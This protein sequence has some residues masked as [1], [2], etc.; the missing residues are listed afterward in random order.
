M[1]QVLHALL[2]AGT[3]FALAAC[4]QGGG[5]S[6]SAGTPTTYASTPQPCNY[7]A[8][9]YGA[10]PSNCSQYSNYYS[11]NP[12]QYGWYSGAWQWP[13][14]YQTSVGSCGCQ[15]GYF[16]VQSHYYG[17]AC[18]PNAYRSGSF[19]GLV[20]F[21]VGSWGPY[22]NYGQN[23][24]GWLNQQQ[25]TYQPPQN[26]NNCGQSTAQGCDVRVA[27]SCPS[28]SRCQAVAGGSTIGLC[29]R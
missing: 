16:P 26:T 20:Y 13:Q 7:Q 6:G 15:A 3:L 19:G 11:Q 4:N 9:A 2:I 14:Y 29:V 12:A 22:W 23:N 21:N 1:K 27:N 17:V 25:A 10:P 24:G 28:G 5:S 18:A 8:G